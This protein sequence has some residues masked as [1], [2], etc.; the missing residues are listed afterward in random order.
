MSASFTVQAEALRRAAG[1]AGAA[2]RSRNF[3]PVLGNVLIRGGPGGTLTLSGTDLDIIVTARVD[4]EVSEGFALTVSKRFLLAVLSGAEGA[5]SCRAEDDMLTVEDGS[6]CKATTC[7]IVPSTDWPG[8]LV[9]AKF[10]G[11]G[12]KTSIMSE[13]ALQKVI[14]AVAPCISTEETR[15][16]L[17]GTY[18]HAIEGRL[19]AVATDGHRLAKY[20]AEEPW[21]HVAGILPIC[22]VKILRAWLRPGGN[23][24][25]RIRSAQLAMQF[26]TE[27]WTLSTKMIDGKFPDYTRVIPDHS[28]L[29]SRISATMTAA[30]LRRL[31]VSSGC[32]RFIE[33]HP[34]AGRM[35]ARDTLHNATFSAPCVGEGKK[36]GM[37]A[38]YLRQFADAAGTIRLVGASPNDPFLV[39]TEDPALTQVLMPARV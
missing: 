19:C 27:D 4:A 12:V 24:E 16:Y 5:I 18:L 2:I 38:R 14:A 39:H 1:F 28:S 8:N 35:E 9:D 37:N 26:S 22:A 3:I 15:Y 33:I 7:L 30:A 6:G 11:D 10:A 25:V 36:F 23:R 34:D 21:E 29:A 32:S 31:P 20:R 13:G 17:N